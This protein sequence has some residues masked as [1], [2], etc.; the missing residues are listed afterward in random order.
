MACRNHFDR[1]PTNFP[2]AHAALMRDERLS[3]TRVPAPN[4]CNP[5]PNHGLYIEPLQSAHMV[6]EN[7]SEETTP[8]AFADEI[9]SYADRLW[10]TL[11][12]FVGLSIFLVVLVVWFAFDQPA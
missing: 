4:V 8:F 6:R 1:F 2:F 11:A 9:F 10:K 7:E 3:R 12:Y 5:V